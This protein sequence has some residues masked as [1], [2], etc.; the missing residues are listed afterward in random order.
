MVPLTQPADA[1]QPL[2][3]GEG[4]A[5]KHFAFREFPTESAAIA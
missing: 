5:Q 4:F 2:T 1:G 3:S